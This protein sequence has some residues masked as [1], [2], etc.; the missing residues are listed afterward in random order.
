[1]CHT[2]VPQGGWGVNF[3]GKGLGSGVGWATP[4]AKVLVDKDFVE[5]N[6]PRKR[7]GGEST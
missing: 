3:G 5:V 6:G 7:K 1:M 4:Y 2:L